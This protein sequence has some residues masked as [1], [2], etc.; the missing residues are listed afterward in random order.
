REN[1]YEDDA[2]SDIHRIMNCDLLII[3]DL[4]TEMT[5]SFVQS[6]LYQIV[7][8]RL[9]GKKTIIST[10]LDPKEIGPRYSPQI[11]SR[12]EGE[13]RILP[14]FGKDIRQL[15]KQRRV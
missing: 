2:Q 5:T 15:K 8:T 4:G 3:D 14:F 11:A 7:N 12:I 10:N 6:V 1:E 13:Y 9:S